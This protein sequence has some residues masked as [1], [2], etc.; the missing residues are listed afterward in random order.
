MDVISFLRVSIGSSTVQL[1]D[2]HAHVQRLVSVVKMATVLEEC[3]PEEQ[4]SIVRFLWKKDSMQRIFI[5]KYFL[6]TVGSICPVKL[7]TVGGKLFANDEEVEMEVRK[8]LRKESKD[9][10]AVGFD[11]LIKRWDK[12]INVGKG[13]VEK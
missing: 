9:F 5:Q 11:V 3:T 4:D 12:C 2:A 10:C 8:G 7:F 13:Y 6:F 1:A